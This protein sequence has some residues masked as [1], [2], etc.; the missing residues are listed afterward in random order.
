MHSFGTCEHICDCRIMNAGT[1]SP[2]MQC[3]LSVARIAD[4]DID[5]SSRAMLRRRTCGESIRYE[6]PKSVD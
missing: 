1:G 6:I 2:D 5:H 4:H 3:L